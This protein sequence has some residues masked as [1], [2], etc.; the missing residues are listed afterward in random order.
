MKVIMP[1]AAKQTV[2]PESAPFS[3]G[4][5]TMSMGG[6]HTVRSAIMVRYET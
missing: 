1:A 6:S 2:S 4:I 3:L 5:V